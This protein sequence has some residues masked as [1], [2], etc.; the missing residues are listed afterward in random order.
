M[1]EKK[2]LN[3]ISSDGQNLKYFY[4]LTAIYIAGMITSLTVAARLFPFHIP[5]TNFTILLTGGTWTIPL[6]FFIQDITTEVYGYSKSRQ[7]VQMSVIILI[8]YVLYMKC[9][10]YLPTPGVSN[11]DA[12]YNTVFN[13]LPRHLFALLAAIFIGNL[14]NDYIISK[15]KNKFGGKYLPLR[16]ITATAIGEAVLQLVG[17]SVAWFGNL[18][19][20]T[21]IL[22]F[23]IFSY[24]YK[25]AFEAIMTPVNV[26]VCKKLKKSEGIDVYDVNINY[27]PFS[28]GSK[29]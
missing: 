6:S 2:L 18:S 1:S 24:L 4:I 9:I 21:Q 13:S 11:I 10:T 3:E 16:F 17:T 29:K 5:M 15:L 23:V 14:V 27:N 28:F 20:T 7:L 8:F 22:P 19:F 12:S 25:V 26:Y